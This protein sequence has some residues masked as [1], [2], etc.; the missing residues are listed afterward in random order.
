MG[1]RRV[2]LV[3][4]GTISKY[5]LH[6]IERSPG[7]ELAAV[8]DVRESALAPHRDTAPCF[9]DHH[10]MLRGVALDA[11]VV[12]AP[13]DVHAPVC[14]D[15]LRAGIP[16]CVEK[17]LSSSHAEGRAL[18]ALSDALGVPLFTA[19]HRR[20]NDNVLGLLDEV[21]RRGGAESLRVRYLE[22][23]E[24][25]IGGDTWYLDPDR[26]GGGCVADNGPNAFDLV[27][28]FLGEVELVDATVRRDG[29][30][31][32]QAVV[33]LRS[34]AG[35]PAVVELD[36]SYPGEAKDV[37]VR[38][39]D[40]TE[41]RADMLAGHPGFKSSLWHEYGGILDDFAAT[42]DAGHRTDDG[43]LPALE[44]VAQIYRTELAGAPAGGEST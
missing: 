32:R 16:V 39:H 14:R 7:W 9:P 11:A 25:H 38:C 27:R 26:C 10:A 43:G 40:G 8:C 6:A 30:V 5:Y 34:T 29:E 4:L 17:P 20:Y 2:G 21:R 19:F 13:N 44:L 18:A 28:L 23:I 22:L 33:E 1:P 15:V 3:G 37:E 12:T 35:V 36:W 41:L 31:D 42:V 24:D